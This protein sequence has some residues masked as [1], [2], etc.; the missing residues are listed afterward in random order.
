M[1][2]YTLAQKISQKIVNAHKLSAVSV[3]KGTC[4]VFEQNDTEHKNMESYG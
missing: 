4:E 3:F 1:T 2:P